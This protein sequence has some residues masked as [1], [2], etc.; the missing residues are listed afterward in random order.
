MSDSPRIVLCVDDDVEDTDD[1]E[2]LTDAF[3][4]NGV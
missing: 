3:K 4:S 2:I 1:I